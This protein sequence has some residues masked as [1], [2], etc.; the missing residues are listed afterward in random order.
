MHYLKLFR[1]EGFNV[2]Q[3]TGEASAPSYFRKICETDTF[4]VPLHI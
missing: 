3:R 1:A 4:F 2:F